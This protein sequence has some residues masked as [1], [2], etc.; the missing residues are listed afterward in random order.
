MSDWI[1]IAAMAENRVIGKGSEIP[2]HLPEDFKWF[3]KTTNGNTLVMGRK[4]FDSIGKPLPNR[5]TV[6][7]SRQK[8]PIQ[9]A[10]LIHDLDELNQIERIGKIFIGGGS[11]IYKL[12][13]P[14]CSELYLTRVKGNF[15]GDILFP[16]FEHYFSSS[17]KIQENEKFSIYHYTK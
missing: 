9:G 6:V 4:T 11:E 16:E 10:T 14:F 5:K 17:E 12:A 7:L 2:W 8:T 1:A 15:E 3:K 13:L